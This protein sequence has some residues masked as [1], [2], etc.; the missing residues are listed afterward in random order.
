[1]TL[2]LFFVCASADELIEADFQE[3]IAKLSRLAD[4]LRLALSSS[5]DPQIISLAA[6]TLGQYDLRNV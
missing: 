6:K 2:T 3:D 5:T 4:Y 1:V